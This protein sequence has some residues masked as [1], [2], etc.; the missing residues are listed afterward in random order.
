MDP[1]TS[2]IYA[3]RVKIKIKSE[4]LFKEVAFLFTKMLDEKGNLTEISIFQFG[5]FDDFSKI[6]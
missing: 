2:L 4:I 6:I 3:E 1:I 5:F